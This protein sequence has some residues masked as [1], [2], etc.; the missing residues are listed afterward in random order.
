[1]IYK[2]NVYLR[3]LVSRQNRDVTTAEFH[4]YLNAKRYTDKEIE[5]CTKIMSS[6]KQIDLF[7]KEVKD[8]DGKR[9][10]TTE[11]LERELTEKEEEIIKLKKRFSDNVTEL[12][13][14][15]FFIYES[16]I[17]FLDDG[18]NNLILK[19]KEDLLEE[20]VVEFRKL[21]KW[22][23]SRA[24]Y[25]RFSDENNDIMIDKYEVEVTVS[26]LDKLNKIRADKSDLAK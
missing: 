5:R 6:N 12:K 21:C 14:E 19:C 22:L 20:L 1:M 3:D 2:N 25:L 11:D 26:F 8:T 23:D 18:G 24:S 15:N 17:I 4:L 16:R 7:N 13:P 9:H 10:K